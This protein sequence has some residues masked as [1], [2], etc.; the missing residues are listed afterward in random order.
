MAGDAAAVTSEVEAAA[1]YDFALMLA[2]RHGHRRQSRRKRRECRH[3]GDVGEWYHAGDCTAALVAVALESRG[4]GGVGRGRACKVWACEVCHIAAS[5]AVQLGVTKRCTASPFGS[6]EK[7]AAGAVFGSVIIA[8]LAGAIVPF[9][10]V[11][12]PIHTDTRLQMHPHRHERQPRAEHLPTPRR[13]SCQGAASFCIIPRIGLTKKESYVL[14]TFG[15]IQVA[16]PFRTLRQSARR[17]GGAQ[18]GQSVCARGPRP[19]LRMAGVAAR[20]APSPRSGSHADADAHEA[21]TTGS[22]AAGSREAAHEG[23]SSDVFS[24][25]FFFGR[26]RGQSFE[27]AWQERPLGSNPYGGVRFAYYNNSKTLANSNV[28]QTIL[29]EHGW[30]RAPDASAEWNLWWCAGQVDPH[31]LSSLLPHQKLN[32]FPRARYFP[33]HPFLPYV[34]PHFFPDLTLY[35]VVSP[36]RSRS[37]AT[38]GR[39]SYG[40]SCGTAGSTTT[41]CHPHSCCPHRQTTPPPPDTPHT[42]TPPTPTPPPP[43]PL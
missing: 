15:R 8:A 17:C 31:A 23:T 30:E 29:R 35:S 9:S 16:P 20:G 32:K 42:P 27:G 41:S 11:G 14:N 21:A 18:D 25:V 1:V 36:A 40:C 22:V 4:G 3:L 10:V 7:V 34:A 26:K 24:D 19:A 2:R 33:T 37:K 28:L 43:R 38:S 5:A 6:R 13:R 39:T 12:A